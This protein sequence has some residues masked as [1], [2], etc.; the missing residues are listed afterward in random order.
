M[1]NKKSIEGLPPIDMPNKLC[2][3]CVAGKHHRTSFPKKSTFQATEPLELIHADICGPI[4]PPTL[5]GSCYFF[6]IIDDYSWLTWVSMLQCKSD[7]FYAFKLFK[8]L[9]E[10][11][12]GLRIKTL[13]SDRGG[14]FTSDEF[15]KYCTDHGIK[16]QLTAPYSPQQNGVVERKNRTV[17]SMVR[18]ILKAKD[19]PRELWGEDVSTCVYILNLSSTKA[20][21][22]QTPHEK[23]IG[24]KPSVDHWRTFGCIVHVKDTRRHLSKL[25]DR[26]KPMIFIGYELGSKA[27][28][29]LDPVNFKVVIS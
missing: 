12:K 24:R 3:S 18:A 29:C 21:L 9:A 20:L 23:W 25:E 11:K 16:R 10:T 19:L 6:L 13:R 17:V 4:T 7:A 14:E 1:S 27:Y 28:K 8:N 22:G 2:Q 5:G 26:S 15:S